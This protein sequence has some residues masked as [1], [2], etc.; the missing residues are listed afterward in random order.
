MARRRANRLALAAAAGDGASTSAR[1]E[2]G[3]VEVSVAD[4]GPGIA[5]ADRARVLGRFVRLE[6]ARSRPG[7]G[8]GLSLAA[9]VARMHGGAVR[10]ED[11]APGLR[12][13]ARLCR[14]PAARAE[15]ARRG[16]RRRDERRPDRHDPAAPRLAA[17]RRSPGAA[18]PG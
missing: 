17:P 9:A 8:L 13:V 16:W 15:P 10:L 2:V 11:N 12:V 4:H 6:G 7:S 5:P 14:P 18:S 3:E 1:R